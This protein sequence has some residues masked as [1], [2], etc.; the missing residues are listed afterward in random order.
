MPGSAPAGALDPMPKLSGVPIAHKRALNR[1]Q[2][3]GVAPPAALR[4]EPGQWVRTLRVALHMTQRQFAARAGVS[5]GQL[6]LLEKG[7]FQPQLAKLRRIFDALYCDLVVLPIPRK[8]VAA[9][10]AE[11]TLGVPT[12]RL[13]DSV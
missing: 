12:R 5:Q 10:L 11:K 3:A 4:L 13:W 9:I 7:R 6:A 8:R 1:L 2:V